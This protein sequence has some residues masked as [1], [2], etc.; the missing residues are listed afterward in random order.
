MNEMRSVGIPSPRVEG[1][2]KVGG[3]ALY[4]VDVTLP[5]MLWAKV[6]RS[7]IA[8]G[9]IK[10]I[11]ISR[12]LALPGVKAVITGADLAGTKIGKK[13]V[14]M[15]L[16]ADEVV[17]YVGEKVAAVAAESE[18]IAEDA[19]DLIEVEYEDLPI[20]TDPLEA[21]TSSAPLLHPELAGYKGLL[22]KIDTPSNVFVHLTW[23]KGEVEEGFRQSDVVVENTFTVP[24][25]HQGYIE[26]HSSLVRV[27]ADGTADIW[28][29][30]KSP[31]SMRDAVGNALRISPS[32]LVVH[33]CYVGG[34]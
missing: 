31:F 7:P 22:H 14:D 19:L 8:H 30:N 5:E 24:A 28:S 4:A 18:A 2:Q 10:N 17:R 20:V 9:R 21:M 23:K 29:S 16:L 12:A 25:V 6:L 11:D 1:E 3:V 27:N 34:D 33:P 26:P 32:S 15:P 13:I